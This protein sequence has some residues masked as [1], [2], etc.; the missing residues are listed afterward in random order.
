MTKRVSLG[1]HR[2]NCSVCSHP[3]RAEIETDF[4]SWR[5]PATMAEEYNLAD[6][7][8]VYPGTY[9]AARCREL[10]YASP[11]YPLR[12]APQGLGPAFSFTLLELDGDQTSCNSC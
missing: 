2:R 6:R 12:T 10:P 7:P 1:R 3:K 9:P 5:S 11:S 4:I 8:S